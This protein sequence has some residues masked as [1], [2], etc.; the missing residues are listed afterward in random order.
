VRLPFP[1]RISLWF[2][3]AFGICLAIVQ[4]LQGSDVFFTAGCFLFIFLATIAFNIAGGFS[5][6]L[7][8]SVSLLAGFLRPRLFGRPESRTLL[9]P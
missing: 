7:T 1:E 6:P 2:S 9:S 4:Q 8:F 5:C 3:V